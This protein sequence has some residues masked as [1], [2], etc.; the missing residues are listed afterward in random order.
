MC[1]H[2]QDCHPGN[3]LVRDDGTV[4]LLDF[5]QAKQL[6][7]PQRLAFARLLV[8]LAAAE[9]APLGSVLLRLTPAQQAEVS[10]A[11][12]GLGIRTGPGKLH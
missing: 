4:G 11:L 3:I 1:T 10:A 9:D 6:A 7:R 2:P 12:A 5:G 8:A